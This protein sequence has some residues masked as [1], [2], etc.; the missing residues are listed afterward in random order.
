MSSTS[1]WASDFQKERIA[2]A[3]IYSGYDEDTFNLEKGNDVGIVHNFRTN[4]P[5]HPTSCS[6]ANREI[7]IE[8]QIESLMQKFYWITAGDRT[9]A[10]VV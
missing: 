8:I 6:I 9:G 1:G 4:T 10:L 3:T 5:P 2:F 7:L